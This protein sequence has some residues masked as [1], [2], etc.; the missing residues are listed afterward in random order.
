MFPHNQPL[1]FGCSEI[2]GPSPSDV[3]FYQFANQVQQ[4]IDQF[5]AELDP[6]A[7]NSLVVRPQQPED[8][9]GLPGRQESVMQQL[10]N[11]IHP[12]DR[13]TLQAAITWA[14]QNWQPWEWEGQIVTLSGAIKWVRATFYPESDSMQE[15][16]WRGFLQDVTQDKQDEAD[17]DFAY[18]L[19]CRCS[20]N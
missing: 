14:M 17:A 3:Q 7:S 20:L 8:A 11:R 5:V 6:S 16:A 18:Y 4:V 12:H 13:P 19:P 9:G 1:L 2:S 10:M 15:L